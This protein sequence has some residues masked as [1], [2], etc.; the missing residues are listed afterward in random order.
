[1][2][3]SCSTPGEEIIS[4]IVNRSFGTDTHITI[5]IKSTVPGLMIIIAPTE[6]QTFDYLDP[7]DVDCIRVIET[8]GYTKQCTII[9][10]YS[11]EVVRVVVDD[12]TVDIF[13]L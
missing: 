13:E 5:D 8:S 10:R 3:T 12:I 1:M 2:T 7:L 11:P 6:E 9:R 4:P